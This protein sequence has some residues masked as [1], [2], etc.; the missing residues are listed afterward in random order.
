[1]CGACMCLRM[2]TS[3]SNY[4]I[5][6]AL[7]S[8]TGIKASPSDWAFHCGYIHRCIRLLQHRICPSKRLPEKTNQHR[9]LPGLMCIFSAR[10]GDGWEVDIFNYLEKGKQIIDNNF[11][12]TAKDR[13]VISNYLNAC[14]GI[15]FEGVKNLKSLK[16][17]R[18]ILSN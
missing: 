14:L 15:H 18:E 10:H 2:C 8:L 1:M 13:R 11:N 16:I 3:R 5:A 12:I 6:Q 9:S 4:A 7:A 17:L